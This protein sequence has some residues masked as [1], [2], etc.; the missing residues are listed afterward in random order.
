MCPLCWNPLRRGSLP[1]LYGR[2]T[3]AQ[4]RSEGTCQGHITSLETQ[5][6]PLAAPLPGRGFREELGAPI[7]AEPRTCHILC[8]SHSLVII[9]L[10]L[11]ISRK[12]MSLWKVHCRAWQSVNI[13]GL[14]YWC[15]ILDWLTSDWL[16][17]PCCVSSKGFFCFLSVAMIII[18][19]IG[20]RMSILL[21]AK[22][23][24][25]ISFHK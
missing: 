22:N 23:Y 14:Y 17:G 5:D 19:F 7:S 16:R 24:F 4:G 8:V 9:A 6:S 20:R 3:T 18:L 15:G 2:K 13:L 12:N 25:K 21:V 11:V 10:V 1:A